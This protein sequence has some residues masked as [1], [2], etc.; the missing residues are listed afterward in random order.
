[1]PL[2]ILGPFGVFFL[3]CIAQ[4]WF[5]KSVRDALIE[6]HPDTYLSIEKSSLFPHRGLYHFTRRRRYEALHDADLDRRVRNLKRVQLIAVGAWLI[7]G[8]AVFITPMH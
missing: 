8:I 7:F 6:R 5:L 1:M 2:Y 3:C 4:F